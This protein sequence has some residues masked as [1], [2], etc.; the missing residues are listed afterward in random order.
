MNLPSV[1]LPDSARGARPDTQATVA[2]GIVQRAARRTPGPLAA[3]LEEEWLAD[4]ATRR[5]SLSRLR[6]ALGCWWAARV[7][8]SEHSAL[9]V[10]AVA[11]AAAAPTPAGAWTIDFSFVSGRT[12]AI[13]VIVCVHLA[14]LYSLA[15][16]LVQPQPSPADTPQARFLP[17]ADSRSQTPP[18]IDGPSL[19]PARVRPTATEPSLPPLIDEPPTV[20]TSSLP[21]V[22][23]VPPSLPPRS[24]ARVIGGTGAGFPATDDFYPLAARRLG[25]TGA[26]TVQV[27]VDASGYLS[28]APTLAASSGVSRL[29]DG[30]LR[31]A[32]AGSGHFRPTTE[33]GRPVSFCF[34][35]RVRF[36]LRK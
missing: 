10:A 27:C 15:R 25:E 34:P 20:E 13:I 16:G 11:G 9:G 24:V 4:L 2:Q 28:A 14:V 33:D 36:E 17:E 12:F 5:G 22:G 18:R 7:I 35:F 30:A 8:L 19:T 21:L 29:D 32:R 26:A 31:L 23:D 6:L 1:P 3:R